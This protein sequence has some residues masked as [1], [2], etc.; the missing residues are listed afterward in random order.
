M[1]NLFKKQWNIK[2]KMY[3]LITLIVLVFITQISLGYIENKKINNAVL[4][5]KQESFA[6]QDYIKKMQRNIYSIKDITFEAISDNNLN[7]SKVLLYTKKIE[8]I[9][10]DILNKQRN[11]RFIHMIKEKDTKDLLIKLLKSVA[12]LNANSNDLIELFADKEETTEDKAA[13]FADFQKLSLKSTHNINDISDTISAGLNDS[14]IILEKTVDDNIKNMTIIFTSSILI[15]ILLSL[16]ILRSIQVPI[17]ELLKEVVGLETVFEGLL[18]SA[19]R[20]ATSLEETAASIEEIT[21]NIRG[22][23]EKAISMANLANESKDTATHGEYLLKENAMA[24]EA[25]DDSTKKI[26]EAISQ[27]EQI[28][29]QTNILS[30]NAAVEAATA[31]EHGKG[32]AVV[33]AEVRNLASMSA[34]VAKEIKALS[35][36]ATNK[37]SV[38]KEVSNDISKSFSELITQITETTDIVDD[39][40]EANKEQLIGMEQI[41]TASNSLDK[42]TQENNILVQDAKEIANTLTHNAKSI[43]G[44]DSKDS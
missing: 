14:I 27:I 16:F 13:D 2:Q 1:G 29:F 37:T 10:E 15:V 9:K 28:A 19:M 7:E 42:L 30:L 6:L 35:V 3:S 40:S 32:F 22:N 33:A 26:V 38:G 4:N 5:L 36:E 31:G 44:F 34:E 17:R 21:G 8:K 18:T 12:I 24:M 11:N 20:Q 43:I 39:V 41:N 25:I 23:N